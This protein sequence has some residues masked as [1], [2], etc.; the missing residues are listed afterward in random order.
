MPP[1][2]DTIFDDSF[3]QVVST[4]NNDIKLL[5]YGKNKRFINHSLINK[6]D[7]KLLS[8][9][10]K[11]NYECRQ[12]KESSL[13][14][15]KKELESLE[16]FHTFL[17]LQILELLKETR[18]LNP[19][20]IT[21]IKYQ[22]VT[23]FIIRII[24]FFVY[25]KFVVNP[26]QYDF[27]M[28]AIDI[29]KL[30]RKKE[31][32]YEISLKFI[33][34]SSLCFTMNKFCENC[35]KKIDILKL[36]TTFTFNT[37]QEKNNQ[38][39]KLENCVL[40]IV[41]NLM[42]KANLP[43]V[44]NMNTTSHIFI[45]KAAKQNEVVIDKDFENKKRDFLQSLK[46]N[47]SEIE[48]FERNTIKCFDKDLWFKEPRKRLSA[49]HFYRAC[50]FKQTSSKEAFLKRTM[51]IRFEKSEATE[52]ED[53]PCYI[54]YGRDNEHKAKE[55]FENIMDLQIDPC[56]V[57]IDEK[58]NYLTAKPDGLIGKDGIVEIKCPV[59]AQNMTPKL[60][61]EQKVIKYVHYDENGD[62]VLKRSSDIFYQIQ[63]ELHITKRHYCYL[64]IW[65]PKGIAY[66]KILQDDKFWNDN[67]EEKLIDFY[68]NIMLPELINP[69]LFKNLNIGGI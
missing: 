15:L 21:R 44:T 8:R 7:I 49:Y 51:F 3:L 41:K 47:K 60:A 10:C 50:K 23:I 32:T 42:I 12:K 57:F 20:H 67:V 63:G 48:T 36:I 52:T 27:A 43:C 34:N 29:T 38:F 58:L 55:L 39:L 13:N 69:Q 33:N 1:N 61:I 56:G 24:S 45:N 35:K 16:C 40:K 59:N 30:E 2:Y 46:L 4:I 28:K 64:I 17:C 31:N 25:G 18:N 11:D 19:N 66:C 26:W 22:Y 53:T 65:T 62:L 54:E 9:S 14:K 68:E 6:D 5:V 37:F